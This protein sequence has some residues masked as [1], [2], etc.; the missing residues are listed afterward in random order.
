M[1][2]TTRGC[3][4]ARPRLSIE[5]N[6]SCLHGSSILIPDDAAEAEVSDAARPLLHWG[7][8]GEGEGGQ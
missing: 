1:L 7:F 6:M 8:E 4:P 2:K 5:L 3:A